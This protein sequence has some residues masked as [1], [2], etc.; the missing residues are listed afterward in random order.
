MLLLLL[1][2]C[3]GLEHEMLLE[4]CLSEIGVPFWTET[5]MRAHGFFKTPD[6]WLQVCALQ[7]VSSEID[8]M[9]A[10]TEAPPTPMVFPQF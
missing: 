8:W 10:R 4:R 7:R 2:P 9:P 1:L 3:T 6:I 5:D